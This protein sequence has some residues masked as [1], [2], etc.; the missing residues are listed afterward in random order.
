MHRAATSRAGGRLLI[1]R[2]RSTQGRAAMGAECRALKNDGETGRATHGREHGVT[3]LAP[4]RACRGRRSATRTSQRFGR[5]FGHGITISRLGQET[6]AIGRYYLLGGVSPW[7]L[8]TSSKGSLS[9]S[10]NG[11][12]IREIPSRIGFQRKTKPSRTA[13]S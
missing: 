6:A 13:R 12:T 4:G 10:S 5:V 7:G 3:V 9:K 8:Q 1:D 2:L 11:R